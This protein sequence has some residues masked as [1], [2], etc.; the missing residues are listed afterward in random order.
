VEIF[1]RN[2]ANVNE[3]NVWPSFI[4]FYLKAMEGDKEMS[5]VRME[6][7]SM[8]LSKDKRE[9]EVECKEKGMMGK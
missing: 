3:K 2:G 7:E 1:L 5:V 8:Y 9:S 6:E 4:L